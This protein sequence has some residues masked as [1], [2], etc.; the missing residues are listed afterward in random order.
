MSAHRQEGLAMAADSRSSADNPFGMPGL[1]LP[2]LL[3]SYRVPGMDLSRLLEREQGNIDSLRQANEA[4][5]E[6]WQSLAARQAE[7]FSESM[8]RW[9]QAME[10]SLSGRQPSADEQ[11]ELLREGF[12]QALEH[13]REMAEIAAES[14]TRAYDIIRQRLEENISAHFDRGKQQNE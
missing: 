8:T 14:Q 9:Q 12:E 6:G 4:V 1:D 13:M 3:E 7:I 10:R 5:V 11:A 2:R